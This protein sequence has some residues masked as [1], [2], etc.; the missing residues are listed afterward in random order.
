MEKLIYETCSAVIHDPIG[1]HR[2]ATRTALYALGFRQ[3]E[4]VPTLE[5]F[6]DAIWRTTPD[7][8][9]CEA[10]GADVELCEMIQNIRQGNIGHTNPFL[11]VI[12]TAWEKTHSLVQRVLNSGADDLI[13]RP[14]TVNTLSQRI[15]THALR[16]KNFVITHDYVGPDR[17]SDPRRSSNVPPFVPPNSLKMKALD[18]LTIS[19]VQ[20]RLNKDLRAARDTLHTQ[21]LRRDVFQI[22]VLWRLLQGPDETTHAANQAKLFALTQ[23][24]I[25]RSRMAG[26]ETA[27]EWCD[28]IQAAAE[29]LQFGVDRNASMHL[30]G[31]AALNLNHLL[32]P[33]MSK[34]DH[35]RAVDQMVEVI[36]IRAASVANGEGTLSPAS[37]G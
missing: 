3:V 14:L 11:V 23:A 15:D 10:Q 13:L 2:N 34:S 21:K 22:C 33:E 36:R 5:G 35:L 29:G 7:L 8:A 20:V 28:S 6:N 16:R 37:N 1:P 27:R 9:I 19:D 18:G 32:D 4:T 26:F 17:R 24:V 31:H 30:L 25:K 12:V